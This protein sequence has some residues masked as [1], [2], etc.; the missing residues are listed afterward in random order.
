VRA[1]A[2]QKQRIHAMTDLATRE[3]WL[4]AALTARVTNEIFRSAP[5][6]S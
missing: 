1:T 6:K 4:R 5:T 2:A 3:R